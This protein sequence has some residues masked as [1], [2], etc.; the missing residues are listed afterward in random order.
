MKSRFKILLFKVSECQFAR[1][2]PFQFVN[3]S[4]QVVLSKF[5]TEK[6]IKILINLLFAIIFHVK[7][8]HKT[9]NLQ[10][11][12]VFVSKKLPQHEILKNSYR[13]N[14]TIIY[15]CYRV[16]SF[17]VVGQKKCDCRPFL[18]KSLNLDG[19]GFKLPSKYQSV[20]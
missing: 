7:I 1:N 20:E 16:V 10:F 13:L 2:L 9:T 4:F 15:F 6:M 14:D 3:L 12:I 8:Q 17:C 19:S 18:V 11:C 5:Y